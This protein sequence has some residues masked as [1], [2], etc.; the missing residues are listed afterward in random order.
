MMIFEILECLSVI[1]GCKIWDPVRLKEIANIRFAPEEDPGLGLFESEHISWVAPDAAH[2]SKRA[3]TAHELA[4][5]FEKKPL[6]IKQMLLAFERKYLEIKMPCKDHE[7][8]YR[9][10]KDQPGS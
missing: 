7:Q 9:N 2:L 8:H 5:L 10:Q 6:E 1:F 3:V 4:F